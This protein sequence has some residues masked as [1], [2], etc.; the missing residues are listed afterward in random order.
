MHLHSMSSRQLDLPTAFTYATARAAGLVDRQLVS[1]VSEGQVERLG[2]GVYRKTDAPPADHDLIEVALGAHDATLC[3]VTALSQHDLS[4]AIPS[5]IDVALPRSRRPPRVGGPVAWH[6]VHDDTFALG[7]DTLDVDDG[8]QIGLHSP[9]RCIVDAFRLRHL[10]GDDVALQ[11]LMRWLRRP[12]AVPAQ[13]L[14]LAR[15]FPKADPSL[16][17]AL[18]VLL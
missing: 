17:H 10:V 5:T 16:L 18:Q 3:L 6:R 13:L 12:D 2:H 9:E 11:S 14:R 7:R 8:V 15:S 4:D 1:L